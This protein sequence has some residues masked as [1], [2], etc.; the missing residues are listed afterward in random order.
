[1]NAGASRRIRVIYNPNSGSK[2]GVSTNR[3]SADEVREIMARHALG[4][5]LVV[6][7]TE[8]AASDAVREAVAAGYDIVAAAGGDGTAGTVACALL[9]T[10]T[11]LGVLPLGSVMNIARMLEIPRDLD[12]AAAIIAGGATR[13]I[14]VGE[15]KDQLFF[16]AGS[17]GM[18]AA[19]FREAQRVDG[20]DPRALLTA[21]WVALR[22]RP[23]RMFIRLDD[24]TVRTRALMVTVANGPYTGIGFTVAP[25]ARLDDGKFDVR[26]FRRFSRWELLR[27]FAAIAFGRRRYAPQIAT[28]RSARVRIEGRRPLPCRVDA[29]DLGT[30]P[31]TFQVR[32]ASLLVVAPPAPV[33][34]EKGEGGEQKGEG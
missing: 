26:V 23:A 18:N 3:T 25:G 22:Y 34:G 9:G 27:H 16:E 2:A 29:H 7:P 5:E 13:V 4:D 20:G 14:D 17:V 11:A 15:A 30:T 21:L 6:T 32:P 19:I 24:R 1:M 28:Y 33:E 12:G 8:E 10:R 31:V